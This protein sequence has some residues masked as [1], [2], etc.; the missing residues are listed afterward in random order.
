VKSEA[1]KKF[2]YGFS[3]LAAMLIFVSCGGSGTGSGG[4]DL[5]LNF[6]DQK[7]E[8]EIT[9]SAYDSRTYKTYL[10]VAA[11]G[12]EALYPG[13]KVNI[14]TFSTM[15][16][17]RTLTLGDSEIYISEVID[18]PQARQDYLNRVNTKL[19]SGAGTD[20][21]AMDILPLH[22]YVESKTL[23]NLE[24]YMN[25]D[26][27]FN[28]ADYRQ[29][30]I[31]A[32]RYKDGIWFMPMDYSFYYFAYDPTLVPGIIAAGFGMDKSFSFEDLLKLGIAMFDT[33]GSHQLFQM[34]WNYICSRLLNENMQSFINLD[35]RRAN[36]VDGRF[37]ALLN[38]TKEYADLGYI[39]QGHS[40][41]RGIEELM[42]ELMQPSATASEARCYFKLET[43]SS[44][45][46]EIITQFPQVMRIMGF[47]DSGFISADNKIAG[48]HANADGLV[49]FTYW[50]GFAVNSQSKNKA[51]AWAFIKYLLS[52]EMQIANLWDIGLAINNKA[53]AEKAEFSLFGNRLENL[54]TAL[55]NQ[56]RQALVEFL[57]EYKA[58]VEKL[59]DSI[60]SFVLL[61][62]S[63]ID[64]IGP[65]LSYFFDGTRSADEVARVLQNRADL[66]LSE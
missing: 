19:M 1:M 60:N 24:P 44:L 48:I 8:G 3:T 28:K 45:I 64:M 59:S 4:A 65:E 10:E 27:D 61:D 16:V 17:I 18:E 66:Y 57:E 56:Q 20:I 25:L 42:K 58:T 30:I 11:R 21:Y 2:F 22:K 35:T 32:L 13:T 37:T 9:I 53:R 39:P 43:N 6:F 23:E 5:S 29:N 55:N 12:F 40:D 54:Q 63:I 52:Y 50:Q 33:E 49:P 7:I 31:E 38:S 34:E 26:P 36:F 41:Q 47:V 51:L 15:P 14:E 46:N 62:A